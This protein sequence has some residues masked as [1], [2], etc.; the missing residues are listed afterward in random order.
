MARR[1]TSVRNLKS[2]TTL[3][4]SRAVLPRPHESS[5]PSLVMPNRMEKVANPL[6]PMLVK[7]QR[8]ES[9][10]T[11][12]KPSQL[13]G[14]RLRVST[15]LMARRVRANEPSPSREMDQGRNLEL[16]LRKTAL[17]LGRARVRRPRPNLPILKR[18][19]VQA[20]IMK[21][22]LLVRQAYTAMEIEK[23]Y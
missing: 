2:I 5:F 9:L 10:T 13:R 17:R 12:A 11:S 22:E 21:R 18:N 20:W 15:P 8:M 16:N 7:I 4:D 3:A 19:R 14:K 6:S 1:L 23:F